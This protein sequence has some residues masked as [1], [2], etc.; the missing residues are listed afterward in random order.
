MSELVAHA[1]YPDL[2]GRV[3]IVTGGS[4]GIGL[5]TTV[6]LAANG[7][8]VAVVARHEA[9]VAAAVE[10]LRQG[11]ATA[12]GVAADCTDAAAVTTMV[13]EVTAELGSPD[14]LMAFAG[15]FTRTTPILEISEQ[16]WRH[17]MDSNVTSTFLCLQAVLPAMIERR[18]GAV[19]TMASNAA[20]FLDI[21][22]TASYAAAKA[23]IVQLTRHVAKEVG[24]HNVRC[25]VVAPATTLTERVAATLPPAAIERLAESAP[26]RRIG[27]AQDSAN[28]AVF[29]VSDAASWLTGITLDV[30]GGRIML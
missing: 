24:P 22:L 12:H 26:L 21:P 27:L 20:R 28:A 9:D 10:Q 14:I 3:A 11:G 25:N 6:E 19:V 1:R 18:R 13:A 30:A 2:A 15:G 8:A 4:K 17:V 23:A 7:V 16:E 5:A 29:L